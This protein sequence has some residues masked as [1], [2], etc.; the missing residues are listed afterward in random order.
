MVWR[1][2]HPRIPTKDVEA[3]VGPINP[4]ATHSGLLPQTEPPS[5]NTNDTRMIPGPGSASA[6]HSP[7]WIPN[8][9][10]DPGPRP[11]HHIDNVT[12]MMY[13]GATRILLVLPLGPPPWRSPHRCAFLAECG[14]GTDLPLG[15]FV[16]P[17]WRGWVQSA[18]PVSR[19]L[20]VFL[21]EP[22]PGR[23]ENTRLARSFGSGNAARIH[24]ALVRVLLRQLSGLIDCRIRF[25]FTPDDAH[26]AVKFWILPEIID[27]AEILL[28]PGLADFR[29]QGGGDLSARLQRAFSTAF[30]DGFKKVAVIGTDCIEIS[31]RWVHAAF[32]QLNGRHDAAIGPTPRGGSHLLALQRHHPA[33]FHEL[34][35][36]SSDTFRSTLA[37][38]A[39]HQI[40]IFQLPPLPVID[41]KS[42]YKAALLGPL[43]PAL[44]QS[45]QDLEG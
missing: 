30:D 5:L 40:P 29:P 37:R 22:L 4:G 21:T 28:D 36:A 16:F 2:P 31:S 17:R 7:V 26:D 38:A 45:M 1:V 33:L 3:A 13:P 44:R 32:S 15:K 27:H 6:S 12:D 23:I 42:E 8:Q 20:L 9:V 24:R 41:R 35:W 39:E 34:P 25:C 43:G 18:P 19:L 14:R 11:I 10:P